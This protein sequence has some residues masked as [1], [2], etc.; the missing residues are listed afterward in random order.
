MYDTFV[1]KQ[2]DNLYQKAL[3][4]EI[5]IWRK[6]KQYDFI[7]ETFHEVGFKYNNKNYYLKTNIDW[8][9]FF[10]MFAPFKKGL[11]LGGNNTNFEEYLINK[12]IISEVENIDIIFKN[13]TSSHIN[14]F[15]DLNFVELPENKYDIIIGKSILH[16]IINLEH[17]L[18]QVNKSLTENGLFIVFEYVGENK[19]QWDQKKIDII[20]S[21]FSCDDI[22]PGYKFDRL[23]HNYYNDW[24]FES[25]R[26]QEI[27]KILHA[28][29]KEKIIEVEWG[30]LSW[31]IDYHISQYCYKNHISLD[32]EKKNILKNR[33]NQLDAIYK[34]DKS[35]KSSYLFGIYKKGLIPHNLEVT[36]WQ[37]SKIRKE[38]LLRGPFIYRIKS[39]LT[40][41]GNTKI[42]IS[43][44]KLKTL[45]K[46]IK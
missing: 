29:F 38:F 18:I 36:K 20:N 23:V 28:L 24:P 14:K 42:I 40:T 19:Q 9:I 22:L 25:I 39:L 35:I 33:A 46:N 15:N 3:K 34:H 31:P 30:K 7:S 27:V 4:R 11:I 32:N 17:L 8:I 43:L 37:K 2:N 26:S 5:G 12:Q 21:E 10:S 16:H 13:H 44:M 41:Y 6:A 45:L 1:V